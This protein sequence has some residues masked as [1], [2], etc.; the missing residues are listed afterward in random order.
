MN[1]SILFDSMTL[2]WEDLSGCASRLTSI[3]LRLWLDGV[4]PLGSA[5]VTDDQ[6]Q[7]ESWPIT[8]NIEQRCLNR[9]VP[10]NRNIFSV[11]L[12]PFR[13]SYYSYCHNQ[14]GWIPLDK[15]RKYAV[16]MESQYSS[17]WSGPPSSQILF[18]SGDK[19]DGDLCDIFRKKKKIYIY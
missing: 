12:N 10:Q 4:V 1:A 8:Y 19:P 16:E 17:A 14:I 3:K 13:D 18:T 7:S 9:P 5:N 2:N 6:N 15:C 11:T